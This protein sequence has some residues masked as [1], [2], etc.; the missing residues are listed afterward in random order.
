MR[1]HLAS[2]FYKLVLQNDHDQKRLDVVL[3][4]IQSA[5]PLLASMEPFTLDTILEIAG[6]PKDAPLAIVNK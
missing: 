6:W 2:S 5:L 1:R 4:I 3:A